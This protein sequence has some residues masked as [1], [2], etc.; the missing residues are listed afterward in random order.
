VNGMA[1]ISCDDL[2]DCVISCMT[3]VSPVKITKLRLSHYCIT[4]CVST[5]DAYF[6]SAI[7]YNGLVF[8]LGGFKHDGDDNHRKIGRMAMEVTM[9]LW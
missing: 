8:I 2:C 4:A 7:R 1:S 9:E 5:C 3:C 6:T